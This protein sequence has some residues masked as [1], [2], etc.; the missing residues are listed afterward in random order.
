VSSGT[1]NPTHSL[2]HFKTKKNKRQQKTDEYIYEIQKW[3]ED[4]GRQSQGRSS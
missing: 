1:L 4:R 2:T 3:P